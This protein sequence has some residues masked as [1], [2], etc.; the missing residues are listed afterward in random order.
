M[1]W[2]TFWFIST[3]QFLWVSLLKFFFVSV[4]PQTY[5]CLNVWFR[6]QISQPLPSHFRHTCSC[7]RFFCFVASIQLA[8]LQP[9]ERRLQSERISVFLNHTWKTYSFLKDVTLQ[10]LHHWNRTRFNFHSCVISESTHLGLIFLIGIS[11]SS[12][13][14][15]NCDAKASFIWKTNQGFLI[16][17]WGWAKFLP[18]RRRHRPW[19]TQV[20]TRF[21]EWHRLVQ[22]PYTVAQLL[23]QEYFC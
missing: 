2:M 11:S 7:T 8:L 22:C 1:T 3:F 4:Y 21:V 18:R 14:C 6:W 19:S 16:C 17:R 5:L 13:Q 15:A 20:G 9:D 23:Y 12:T 10:W